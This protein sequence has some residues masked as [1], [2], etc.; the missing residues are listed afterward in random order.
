MLTLFSILSLIFTPQYEITQHVLVMKHMS[1]IKN[2]QK[3][4]V[5]KM[6]YRELIL[7]VSRLSFLILFGILFF[8]FPNDNAK[9]LQI[10]IYYTG[11][12]FLIAALFATL[13]EKRLKNIEIS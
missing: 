11:S 3:N 10:M 6:I 7:L 9:I 5:P 2:D 4:F 12:V 13:E 1:D 8:V